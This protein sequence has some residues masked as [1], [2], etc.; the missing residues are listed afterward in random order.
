MYIYWARWYIC[1]HGFRHP[2]NMG[3]G[4]VQLFLAYLVKNHNVTGA[5][6]IH[7]LCALLFLYKKLLKIDLGWI[8]SEPPPSRSRKEMT[9]LSRRQLEMPLLH[10]KNEPDNVSRPR[11]TQTDSAIC[12]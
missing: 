3:A 7:A 2:I 5:A 6:Y 8:D 10:T 11:A 4:E 12:A 9:A 1:F